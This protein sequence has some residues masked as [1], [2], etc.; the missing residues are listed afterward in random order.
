[1]KS[2]VL[3]P[4]PV[5]IMAAKKKQQAQVGI[6]WILLLKRRQVVIVLLLNRQ[7]LEMLNRRRCMH[8]S[9]L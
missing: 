6:F 3:K 2:S 4:K 1:M 7:V 9:L 5:K 8:I